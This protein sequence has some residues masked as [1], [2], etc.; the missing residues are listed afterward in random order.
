MEL[1]LALHRFPVLDFIPGAAAAGTD[2]VL[3]LAQ[4]DTGALD[5]FCHL[6]IPLHSYSDSADCTAMPESLPWLRQVDED[7]QRHMY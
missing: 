5:V 1:L 6:R 7:N 4:R 3:E 2:F